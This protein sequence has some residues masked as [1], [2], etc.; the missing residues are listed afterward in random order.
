MTIRCGFA[1]AVKCLSDLVTRVPRPVFVDWERNHVAMDDILAAVKEAAEIGDEKRA[2]EHEHGHEHDGDCCGHG[3]E[4][5]GDCCGHDHD[6]HGD[7][8]SHEHTEGAGADFDPAACGGE[9]ISGDGG[10]LKKIIVPGDPASGTP[11]PGSFVKVHYVG[12]LASD[13]SKFDS[14]RDRPGFFEFDVGIGRVI[15]GWDQGIVTMCKGEKCI[16]ACRSDYA[17]GAGGS[18]P[19]IPGGATLL[20]EVE[21]FAWKE[22]RKEKSQMGGEERLESAETSKAKGTIAFKAGQYEE[23]LQKYDDAAYYVDSSDGGFE[24][25]E[26]RADEARQL[27]LSCVLNGATCALKLGEHS[28]VVQLCD[29]ALGLDAKSVKALFRRG[30]ARMRLTEWAAAKADLR[31]ASSLDPKSKEVR[32]A[33]A[34]CVK[35]EAEA[36]NKEK[37]FAARMFG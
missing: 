6:E 13:G 15:K 37:A 4:H 8:H 14:S 36:K 17:Y 1:L 32:D 10:I 5:D 7:G 21:L 34:E 22:K 35:R 23:A 30:S 16:L 20:F 11:P 33:F 26:G 25:P 18:P 2:H 28:Q 19:K 12:T 27:E 31:Q 9:D 3:H 24:P 29:R